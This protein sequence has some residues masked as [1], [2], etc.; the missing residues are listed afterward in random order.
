[1]ITIMNIVLKKT[2]PFVNNHPAIFR[3]TVWR[4]TYDGKAVLRL[5]DGDVVPLERKINEHFRLYSEKGLKH[6]LYKYFQ[7]VVIGKRFRYLL[8]VHYRLG[9]AWRKNRSHVWLYFMMLITSWMYDG[10]YFIEKLVGVGTIQLCRDL[11]NTFK[12]RVIQ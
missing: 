9:D 4:D 3:D 7:E 12:G 1:M 10:V 11:F 8:N 2:K 5:P 6:L